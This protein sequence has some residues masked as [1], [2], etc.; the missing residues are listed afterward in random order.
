MLV[1]RLFAARMGLANDAAPP[2]E[3]LQAARIVSSQLIEE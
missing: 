3:L 2:A 1:R